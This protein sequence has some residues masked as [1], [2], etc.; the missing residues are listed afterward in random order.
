MADYISRPDLLLLPLRVRFL[1]RP[2]HREGA[3]FLTG[4]YLGS[5]AA[6]ACRK[7]LIGNLPQFSRA[8]A[9]G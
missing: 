7:R 3:L 5:T 6:T 1:E 8:H 4:S 2:S 9:D